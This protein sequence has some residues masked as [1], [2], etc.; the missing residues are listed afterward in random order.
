MPATEGENMG[1]KN[2]NGFAEGVWQDEINVRNF[3][4]TN[5]KEYHGDDSFLAGPTKRTSDLMDKIQELFKQAAYEQ[6][7]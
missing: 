6:V 5:Y 4:Q 1:H 2:W 7:C 3:I